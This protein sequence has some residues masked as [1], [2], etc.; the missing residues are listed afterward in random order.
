MNLCEGDLADVLSRISS[1][2]GWSCD[3][4]P[5]REFVMVNSG[6][7]F[8]DSQPVELRVVQTSSD[9][10][11]VSDGGE[12]WER[13]TGAGLDLDD[14]A[15]RGLWEDAIYDQR[16]EVH[17]G[18]LFVQV[19]L[20]RAADALVRFADGLVALDALR[21]VVLPPLS[22]PKTLADE[23]ESFLRGHYGSNE[24]DKNPTVDVGDG[25]RFRPSLLVHAERDV[26]LQATAST[27]RATA[28]EHAFTMFT[29]A[30]NDPSIPVESR[31]VVLGG[32]ESTWPSAKIRY[33]ANKTAYVGFWKYRDRVMDFLDGDTSERLLLPKGEL[34][35]PLL[36]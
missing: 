27:G 32:S 22:R 11:I 12:I 3:P 7:R 24:I 2:F 13:L 21:L 19:P 10:I 20:R 29:L 14:R 34:W 26:Y 15:H 17:D 9:E 28:F 4:V 1:E 6:R 16:L 35:S 8:S 31:L 5:N 18:R 23:V 36:P 33:L 30:N 25:L